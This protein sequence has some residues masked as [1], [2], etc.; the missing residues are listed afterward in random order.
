MKAF[1]KFTIS[2]ASRKVKFYFKSVCKSSLFVIYFWLWHALRP[3]SCF[4][5]STVLL[6]CRSDRALVCLAGWI[7]AIFTGAFFQQ[8]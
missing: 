4:F 2:K 8:I 7:M 5:P 3:V 1:K 6:L